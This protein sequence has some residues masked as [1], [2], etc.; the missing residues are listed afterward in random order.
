M[1]RGNHDADSVISRELPYPDSVRRFSS[2]KAETIALEEY[3]VALHG[4]SFPQRLITTDFVSTYPM[5]A[6][7]GSTL[8]CCSLTADALRNGGR[9]L[10]DAGGRLAETLA[11]SSAG[12]PVRPSP[13][14]GELRHPRPTSH[15][16]TYLV[17]SI[18]IAL[19]LCSLGF[20][21]LLGDWQGAGDQKF[22]F[23]PLQGSKSVTL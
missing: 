11:A 16:R 14:R 9:E 21:R 13:S 6:K 2:G 5:R 1:V 23:W 19:Q 15:H 10:L 22:Y 8:A 4:R 3:K 12:C 18:S 7:D 17:R 20:L